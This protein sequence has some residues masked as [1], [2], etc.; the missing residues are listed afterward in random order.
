[1]QDVKNVQESISGVCQSSVVIS[2][3]GKPSMEGTRVL[4]LRVGLSESQG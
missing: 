3:A 2:D 4:A 1:M